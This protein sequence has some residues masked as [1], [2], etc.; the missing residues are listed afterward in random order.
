MAASNVNL[1]AAIFTLD[2]AIQARFSGSAFLPNLQVHLLVRL[3]YPSS[4]VFELL[5]MISFRGRFV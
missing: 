1:G 2:A 3:V 5:D 4:K